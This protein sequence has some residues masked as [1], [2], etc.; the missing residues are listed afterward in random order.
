[1]MKRREFRQRMAA[2]GLGAAAAGTGLTLLD[3]ENATFASNEHAG[4]TLR[5]ITAPGPAIASAVV[6]SAAPFK[7]LTGATVKRLTA[8]FGDLFTKTMSNFVTPFSYP[9]YDVILCPSSWLGD[10]SPYVVN[11]APFIRRD[12]SLRWND[13]I[14]Q[15]NGQWAGKQIAMPI[16]GEFTFLTLIAD[17]VGTFVIHCHILGHEDGGMMA[18]VRVDP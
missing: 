12:P 15:R 8:P 1:M 7:K 11:L 2:M 4:E 9:A 13:I 10:Y 17:F 16:D 5:V 18:T 3:P 14:Y 6:D